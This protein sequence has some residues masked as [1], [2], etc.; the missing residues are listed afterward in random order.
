M[1]GILGA[2][3]S[4]ERIAAPEAFR[5]ALRRLRHRGPDDEGY[6]LANTVTRQVLHC[7]GEDTAQGLSLPKIPQDGLDRYNALLGFRRLSIL[8]LSP[9]GHQPMRSHDGLKWLVFNGE[10]Y[11]FIELREELI[12][13][14]C[15]FTSGSDS[16]VIL[17]AY[18]IWGVSCLQRFIGMW[19]FAILDLERSRLFCARDPFGIKPFY[20]TCRAS[21]FT[22]A[23]EIKALLEFPDTRREANPQAL[24]DYLRHGLTDHSEGTLFAGIKQLRGGYYLDIPLRD[25][26]CAP[27]PTR[28][29]QPDVKSVTSLGYDEAAN[30][31]R[32]LFLQ[33]IRIHLRSDVP[34]GAALSGGI[35]SSAIVSAMR[36][37]DPQLDLRTFS[38]INSDPVQGEERWVNCI[39]GAS[40]AKCYKTQPAAQDLVSQL[41]Q[42]VYLQD[43]PFGSSSMFA[44]S[45]VFRLAREKG[46]TVMLDGQGADE[47]FGGYPWH[48]GARL[49]SLIKQFRPLQALGFTRNALAQPGTSNLRYLLMTGGAAVLPARYHRLARRLA[50]QNASSECFN[51]AWFRERDVVPESMPHSSGREVL[52]ETLM[53]SAMTTLP[54]LLRYEDRNSMAH[55]IESR[56]PFLT[57]DLAQFVFS[58]PEHYLL[59]A[60]GTL[61]SILRT[62]M[63]GIVPD[64]VLDR[65]DKIAFATPEQQWLSE[66]RPWVHATL[67]S[68]MARSMP[69]LN[70]AKLSLA[71]QA[72]LDGEQ[73]FDFRI[74]RWVNLIAWATW[75][76]VSFN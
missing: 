53:H 31:V 73:R 25:A 2:T 45:C 22:F 36:K 40:H 55:S 71:W 14:G 61:K 57:T 33:N 54:M 75:F 16:E 49:A 30:E 74:W 63:R 11:N 68:E 27:T 23:S 42:L 56:V 17:S 35:D 9:A 3:A 60:D 47:L 62:A 41:D 28:Y 24:N 20:Y 50:A 72:V 52:R 67:T 8:D 39:A 13:I 6:L 5:N 29:W 43:E 46:V 4:G 44:Q 37:T 1:C 59:S 34:V 69:A 7:G 64:M 70:P 38:Y 18:Q 58:L 19:A 48:R 65:R 12:R 21:K 32:R 76:E 10:I 26:T 51:I 15:R 66:L